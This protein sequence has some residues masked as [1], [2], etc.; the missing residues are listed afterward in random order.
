MSHDWYAAVHCWRQTKYPAHGQG[1]GRP[2]TDAERRAE[3]DFVVEAGRILVCDARHPP[4][5]EEPE[6]VEFI[7]EV[8]GVRGLTSVPIYEEHEAVMV[9]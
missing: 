4:G 5:H 3:L 8:E 2:S 1:V 9:A 7:A 6:Q